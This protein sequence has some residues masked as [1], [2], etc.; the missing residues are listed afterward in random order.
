M[1]CASYRQLAMSARQSSAVDKALRLIRQGAT[2]YRAAKTAGIAL[3]TIYAALQ[4]H[5][6]VAAIARAQ[7][8]NR[9]QK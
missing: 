4:R 5:P 7:R 6:D 9:R 8:A 1:E 3:P 2:P